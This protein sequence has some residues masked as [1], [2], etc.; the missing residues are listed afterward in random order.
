MVDAAGATVAVYGTLRRGERNHD[1]LSGAE[2]L[3]TGLV[4]GTIHHI[5]GTDTWP[6]PYPAL[7]EDADGRVLV[8]VYRLMGLEMLAS[9]DALEA[10]DPSDPANSGYVRRIVP[11]MDGPV[12]TAYVYFHHGEA[13]ELGQ[14]I[15][16]GDWV[17]HRQTRD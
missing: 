16:T 9:L 7:V 11:V 17:A 12:D 8:E 15:T 14:A 2:F 13:R 5:A 6:Y 1:L 10:F 4:S 3:G